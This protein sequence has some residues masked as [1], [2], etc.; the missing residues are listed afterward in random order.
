MVWI[1]AIVIVVIMLFT[2]FVIAN[3]NIKLRI[4]QTKTRCFFLEQKKMYFADLFYVL[5]FCLNLWRINWVYFQQ[6]YAWF[7]LNLA[8]RSQTGR[9]LQTRVTSC[10]SQGSELQNW[11]RAVKIL[12]SPNLKTGSKLFWALCSETSDTF[13]IAG[14]DDTVCLNNTEINE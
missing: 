3:F 5:L 12:L 10:A 6:I 9:I 13:R 8:F 11:N 14:C 4:R 1:F 7:V 2:L